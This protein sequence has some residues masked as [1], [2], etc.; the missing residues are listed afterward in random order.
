MSTDIIFSKTYQWEYEKGISN[1]KNDLG[2]KTND[3]ITYDHYLAYC[4]PVLRRKP[5]PEHF[6]SLTKGEIMQ[7]YARVWLRMGCDQINNPV[8]AGICFDFGFNSGFAKREIQE[9]LIQLGYKIQA[10]NIFGPQTIQAL[11]HAHKLYRYNLIDLILSARLTYVTELCYRNI[12][13]LDFL[14]GWFNRIMDWR[15]FALNSYD[16]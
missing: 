7:F 1:H 8:L 3:G 5:T 14:K 12:T 16:G 10:D 4:L 9:V 15:Q 11:N 2:G 13:Q 6:E